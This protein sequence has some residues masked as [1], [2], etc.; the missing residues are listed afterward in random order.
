MGWGWRRYGE[1]RNL[2]SWVVWD[3]SVWRGEIHVLDGHLSE[4]RLGHRTK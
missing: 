1:R 2:A 4:F 3:L